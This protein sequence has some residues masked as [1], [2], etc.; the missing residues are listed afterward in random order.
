VLFLIVLISGYAEGQEIKYP[1]RPITYIMPFPAGNTSDLAVRLIAKEAEKFLGQPITV[2]NKA[3]ASGTLGTAALAAAKPDGYTIG[4]LGSSALFLL[5]Y[6]EKLPYHPV[7]DF[8]YILQFGAF[9]MGV[10]VKADSPFKGFKDLIEYARQNPKKLTYGT[11]GV[12]SVQHLIMEL[13]SRKEKIQMTHIPFKGASEGEMALLGGHI[14]CQVGDFSY[15]L[16]EGKQARV[17]LILR[18]EK[19]AEY[20]DVPVLKDLGYDFWEPA[21]MN[22]T[23]PKGIPEE[24]FKKLEE[25]FTKAMKEP[26]FI[27]GMKEIRMPIFYRNSKELKDYVAYN[28]EFWGKFLREMG[29]AK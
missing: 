23:V 18:Q 5:P 15:S 27:K 29:L 10:V 19:S 2:V 8:T 1:T 7:N 24:I 20:P 14:M 3:G 25:A 28:Y 13:I 16:I 11:N 9:N 21:F 17:I 26:G 22:V 4:H 6:F 12:N